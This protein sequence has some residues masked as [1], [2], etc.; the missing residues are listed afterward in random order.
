MLRLTANRDCNLPNPTCSVPAMK[1]CEGLGSWDDGL[2]R[3]E[4][5]APL[6]ATS[7]SVYPHPSRADPPA[8]THPP[9][10]PPT[11]S[12]AFPRRYIWDDCYIADTWIRD[13]VYVGVGLTILIG[14]GTFF[15]LAGTISPMAVLKQVCA[16]QTLTMTGVS[17][18]GQTVSMLA[19]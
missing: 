4:C 5:T 19:V 1:K 9:T 7:M 17:L 18:C 16:E 14:T 6:T 13:F 10:H 8:P 15:N 12:L 3:N 2:A 11:T